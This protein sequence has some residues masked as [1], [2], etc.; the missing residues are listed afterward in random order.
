MAEPTTDPVVPPE[1]LVTDLL[2]RELLI[3]ITKL[4][5]E[6][7]LDTALVHNNDHVSLQLCGTS[8]GQIN[9]VRLWIDYKVAP[10]VEREPRKGINAL[11]SDIEH[12]R[13]ELT[14]DALVARLATINGVFYSSQ[15]AEREL[16]ALQARRAR[17]EARRAARTPTP[18]ITVT[19]DTEHSGD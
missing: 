4:R 14:K 18:G 15:T 19:D 10:L 13:I 9:T 1:P 17:V 2:V 5:V 7:L 3:E 11:M 16:A 8:E 6:K 12:G